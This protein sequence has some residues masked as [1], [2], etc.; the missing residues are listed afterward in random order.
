MK[1]NTA[2][3]KSLSQISFLRTL[4][5]VIK[6]K[7]LNVLV[8]P[9]VHLSLS[10]TSEVSGSGRLLLGVKWNHLSHFPSEF[11]L[12]ESA[13]LVVN[14]TFSVYTNFHMV[15]ADGAK[16]TVGE[17]YINNGLTLDCFEAITIGNNVIISKGVTIRDSDNH[18]INGEQN[19]SAPIEIG[20]NV[21]IGLN[22]TIL[23]GVKIGDGAV[24]AAGAVVTENVPEKSLVGGVP[25]KVIKENVAWA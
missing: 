20:D 23:K 4:F 17:G 11:R 9:K 7:V 16:L 5:F 2:V 1:F 14:G 19:I 22:V 24:I 12:G 10:S 15:V 13:E 21:W 6:S 8:Y 3:V 25:A 18:S